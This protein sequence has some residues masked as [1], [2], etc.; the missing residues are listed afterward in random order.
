METDTEIYFYKL[1]DRFGYMSNFYKCKFTDADGI[2]YNCSEQYFMYKKCITFDSGNVE[3]L[4]AILSEKSPTKIKNYGRQVENYEE[5]IWSEKRY[6]V[7]LEGLRLKFSQN[8]NLK[9]KLL[10]TGLKTLY[11]ASKRDNIW[12]I[13]FYDIDAVVRD[14]SEYGSNLLGKAL[15]DIRTEL[16]VIEVEE[17]KIPGL[18]YVSDIKTD[19]STIISELDKLEWTPLTNSANSRVVQHYGYKY[20]Y[21][22]RKID[23]KCEPLPIFLKGLKVLLTDIC[24]ELGLIDRDYK[25]NQCIVNN[26]YEGQRISPHIDVKSYGGV[27]GCFTFGAGA[28]ILF[29]NDSTDVDVRVEPNSLYIISGD[30]RYKWKHSMPVKKGRTVSITFRNV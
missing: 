29:S 20:D 10:E 8:I 14:K 7:M 26:Y 17:L 13:G 6:N 24:R 3:L 25:F 1:T 30:S 12:G 11:E 4:E 15:M 5:S 21:V 2:E 19:T 9:Q 27:I 18:F 23:Q 16:N 22:S 28:V